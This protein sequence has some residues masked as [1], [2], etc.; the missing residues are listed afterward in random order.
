MTTKTRP[1]GY[2]V[3]RSPRPTDD[4]L[5][6]Q[7]AKHDEDSIV[8]GQEPRP[9]HVVIAVGKQ[10]GQLAHRGYAVGHPATSVPSAVSVSCALIITVVKYAA[11]VS[12]FATPRSK[13]A[14][15]TACCSMTRRHTSAAGS[16]TLK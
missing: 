5:R 3:G 12:M 11:G 8:L 4:R 1:L 6:G 7:L 2:R 14:F 10:L 9:L 15:S 13:A 16:C